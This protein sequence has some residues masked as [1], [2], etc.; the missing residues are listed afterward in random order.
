VGVIGLVA[1]GV[2]GFRMANSEEL[3]LA[4]NELSP[5]P[6]STSVKD[7]QERERVT[8]LGGD[9]SSYVA[10]V[11]KWA[12]ENSRRFQPTNRSACHF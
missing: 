7:C 9:S 11:P 8:A 1:T 4:A 3:E 12:H 5:T 6:M 10:G 2:L